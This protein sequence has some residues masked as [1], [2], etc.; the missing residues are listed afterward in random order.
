MSGYLWIGV[1]WWLSGKESTYNSG[2]TGKSG[3]IPGSG[4]SPGGGHG[5]PLQDSCLEN[6]MDRGAW[7]ATVHRVTKSRAWLKWLSTHAH[8]YW[9]GQKV[10]LHFNKFFGQPNIYTLIFLSLSL[11]SIIYFFKIWDD[12]FIILL[13]YLLFFIVVQELLITMASLTIEHGLQ[14][15]GLHSLQNASSTFVAHGLSCAMACGILLDQELNHVPCMG[16]WVL[17][18]HTTREVL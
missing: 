3:S 14:A 6:P 9:A 5:N 17:I 1:S 11:S 4:R 8:I 10:C 2:I 16:R 15:H 13:I 7:Q 12:W 18:Y